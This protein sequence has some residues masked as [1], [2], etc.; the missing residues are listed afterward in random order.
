M[1]MEMGGLLEILAGA[2]FGSR[3]AEDE[4]KDLGRYFVETAQWSRI[5]SGEK[6]VV[7]GPKGAG[8]SAIFAVLIARG[9]E[10][11]KDGIVVRSAEQARGEPLFGAVLG[12]PPDTEDEWRAL[13]RAYFVAIAAGVLEEYAVET[14]AAK[15]VLQGLE[16]QGLRQGRGLDAMLRGAREFARRLASAK[17][18]EVS[19][20]LDPATG[21]LRAGARVEMR[22]GESDQVAAALAVASLLES[23]DKA[24][25]EAGLEVW[26]ALDRLDAAFS[27]SVVETQAIRALM[28]VYRDLANFDQI[29]LK[30]FL[31]QDIWEAIVDKAGFREGSH[32]VRDE[33]IHW[34]RDTLLNLAVRRVLENPSLCEHFA[35]D[36]ARV[37]GSL[38]DQGALFERMF[39]KE[40]PGERVLDRAIEAL[41]DGTGRTAPRELMHLLYEMRD[42][43]I[44]RLQVGRREPGGGAL[45]DREVRELALAEVSRT[46]LEKTLYS[47]IPKVKQ[48][49]E[50]L[51]AGPVRYSQQDLDELWGENVDSV[52]GLLD[53]LMNAGVMRRL[54][55]AEGGFEVA[56]LYRPA[57][58]LFDERVEDG[59]DGG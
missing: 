23:V 41:C 38:T 20:E 55:G 48:Y 40:D 4:M 37:L 43:Q 33:T 52:G 3:V 31:R 9:G 46:H 39:E 24:L 51:R 14:D 44:E 28:R 13:W 12:D 32:I 18:I 11:L 56:M 57:L 50:A 2:G 16:E 5:R 10:L 58:E 53:T 21:G 19:A 17:G 35:V 27:D 59:P 22:D 6:D 42:R 29:T 54:S 25:A 30:I 7:Y 1:I 49:V 34:N 47:E 15:A 26:I 36:P 45:F 8:K